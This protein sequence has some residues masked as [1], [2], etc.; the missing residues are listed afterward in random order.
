[1]YLSR[2]Q[3]YGGFTALGG[4]IAQVGGVLATGPPL[5]AVLELFVALFPTAGDALG[6]CPSLAAVA[7]GGFND[8]NKLRSAIDCGCN[9]MPVLRSAAR[10]EYYSTDPAITVESTNASVDNVSFAIMRATVCTASSEWY[11]ESTNYACVDEMGEQEPC[12]GANATAAAVDRT[13]S[14]EQCAALCAD[15]T[16]VSVSEA[17][18]A[19]AAL[20]TGFEHPLDGRYCWLWL[21]GSCSG[22]R[23]Y[24]VRSDPNYNTYFQPA[25]GSA[26]RDPAAVALSGYGAAAGVC[27][28]MISGG[29]VVY[30]EGADYVCV[31]RDGRPMSCFGR[32]NVTVNQCATF[33]QATAIS[34]DA[35]APHGGISRHELQV[36]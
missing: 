26:H 34:E 13:I 36:L 20:C 2:S 32:S 9:A 6:V 33:C 14:A 10:A 25:F 22:S 30:A 7:A 11:N 27:A 15:F 1:M 18:V 31:D 12:S 28:T 24:N 4:T 21:D 8:Q 35:G 16:N 19:T 3:D 29:V 23:P 5:A 17:S